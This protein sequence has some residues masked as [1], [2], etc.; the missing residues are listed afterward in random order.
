MIKFILNAV[1]QKTLNQHRK[2][3]KIENIEKPVLESYFG[4]ARYVMTS[5]TYPELLAEN[6]EFEIELTVDECSRLDLLPAT[7][8]SLFRQPSKSKHIFVYRF[9]EEVGLEDYD[10]GSWGQVLQDS[11]LLF[12]AFEENGKH[13]V[14]EEYHMINNHQKASEPI[15]QLIKEFSGDQAAYAELWDKLIFD[16]YYLLLDNYSFCRAPE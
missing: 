16:K 13:Y 8:L 6:K 15:P 3:I 5:I 2:E 12:Y 9:D 4:S 1:R 10:D 14:I 7:T 11:L